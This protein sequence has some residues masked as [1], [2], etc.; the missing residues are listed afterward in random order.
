MTSLYSLTEIRAIEHAAFSN[1][2]AG[3]L[4]KR[5]GLSAANIA[6]T[7]L[8]QAPAECKILVLAGPG[9]NGGDALEA[10]TQLT[11]SGAH[12]S[13]LLFA[14]PAQQ[15]PDAQQAYARA[16]ESGGYFADTAQAGKLL[17][18]SS[19]S[20]QSWALI[21]DGLFGIGLTREIT[22][23]LHDLIAKINRHDCP[24]LALDIPS[25]LDAD[26]GNVVGKPGIAV[27]ATHTLS[28]IADK[29]GL[30]TAD[31]RDY[32][33]K[34]SIATLDIDPGLYPPPQTQLS[35][36]PLFAA[37]LHR[38]LQNSHKGSYGD[39]AIV[40]G[41]HGM[42]GAPILAASAAAK[43]GAGRTFVAFVDNPP[44]YDNV[45][46]ELMCRLAR[47][48]DFS[49]ATL[50]VGSGLGNSR[51]AGDLLTRALDSRVP[52]V[53]DADA[54]NLIAAAPE[55]QHKLAARLGIALLTP[56]PLEAARLL[57]TS[58]SAI[59]A[60]RLKAAR[61]IASR[62]NAVVVLKGSGTVIARPDGNV[63]INPTGNPGLATAGTGD[64]LAGICGAL[65]SQ[66][67]P[68]WEA[69]LG[70][71]WLHGSAADL[72]VQQGIGPIGMTAS[73]L[74]PV[75]RSLLNRLVAEYVPKRGAS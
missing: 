28:F 72:L 62:F 45:Q 7:L 55:L 53:L 58:A 38:R 29:P 22:G 61:E 44:A 68:A 40:G 69:A 51:E 60:D 31:G 21:I 10:A 1:L 47:D 32:A 63:A 11:R 24:V 6:L 52:L 75:V 42:A 67:W 57:A 14:D 5:A 4:M 70:A 13:I 54:L 34:I 49:S 39:V 43:S 8:Q 20:P 64:V 3:T 46:A 15:P 2:P 33:G 12:V 27:R 74:I 23:T 36:I 48:V 16:Q 17:G 18:E 50:V 9:N 41:A 25:G 73:E 26:T 35:N 59:Q 71:V 66:H 65:L 37:A 56:H 19:Q 30:H